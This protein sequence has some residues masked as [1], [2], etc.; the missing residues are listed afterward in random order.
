MIDYPEPPDNFSDDQLRQ[1]LGKNWREGWS[2]A[3]S[4]PEGVFVE[5]GECLTRAVVLRPP[6][7]SMLLTADGDIWTRPITHW[8]HCTGRERLRAEEQAGRWTPAPAPSWIG[9]RLV[10]L[11]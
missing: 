5:V 9:P 11:P 1:M 10:E 7:F 2:S 3:D 4:I 6:H 8:R